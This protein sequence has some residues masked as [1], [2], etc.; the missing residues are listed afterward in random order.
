MA[1]RHGVERNELL[2]RELRGR[3]GLITNPSGV[4]QNLR[5]TVDLLHER[6][7]LRALYAPEHGIRGDAQAG[8]HIE[9][10]T[11]KKTGLPVYSTYGTKDENPEDKYR[12]IDTLVFD[13]QDVGAR[14]YTYMYTMTEAMEAC[15]KLGKRV[16]VLDRYN[17]LGLS[18]MEGT[19]LDEKFSSFVGK[20][21]LASRYG[22]TIGEFARYANEEKGIGCDLTVIPC[23]GL[24]RCAD[25]RTLGVPWVLPSPNLPTYESALVYIGTVLFEGTNV[26]EGRGTTKPFELIG[27]PFIDGDALATT[28][29]RMSLPGVN[30][31]PACF[32]PTFSK[33]AG[34]RCYGVQIHVTNPDAF[35]PF[36]TG[37]LLLDTIRKSYE[38]FEFRASSGEKWTIDLILGTNA[39]R[40]DGFDAETIIADEQKK[41][42]AF[43]TSVEKYFLYE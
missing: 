9:H 8:A 24:D 41:V 42:E 7:D 26:S 33:F 32:T 40:Q 16:V 30:F 39:L 31:R 11:D 2:P 27:A 38:Q 6:Y 5:A 36:R 22:M 3:L 18:R 13:I 10:D 17:P 19:L 1:Y 28:M 14:F 35:E 12:D 20:Y 23:E 21:T 34:E 25:Y 4:D 29:R 43:K 37:L 15:A